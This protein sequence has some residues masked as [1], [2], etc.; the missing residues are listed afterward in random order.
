LEISLGT[1][2]SKLVEANYKIMRWQEDP[3]SE[4]R[5]TFKV[6]QQELEMKNL[7]SGIKLKESEEML[8]ITKSEVQALKNIIA[9]QK[10]E[11]FKSSVKLK[12]CF[13]GEIHRCS[14]IPEGFGALVD[15]FRNTF[16]ENIPENFVL[17]Y[18][19]P[20]DDRVT[21]ANDED[22][23]ALIKYG[24]RTYSDA[25]KIFVVA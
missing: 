16:K 11:F 1:K 14:K 19:D 7:E 12:F 9:T 20:E 18:D 10:S 17:S 15:S 24:T 6:I 8:Q 5:T 4:A 23:V 2:D 13:N 22:Y 21:L 3:E 25:V